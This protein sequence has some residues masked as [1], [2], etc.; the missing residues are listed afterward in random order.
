MQQRERQDIVRAR[1]L[2]AAVAGIAVLASAAGFAL[3]VMRHGL[4]S[5]VVL[6]VP[7]IFVGFPKPEQQNQGERGAER[8]LAVG[9]SNKA[10]RLSFAGGA[11]AAACWMAASLN[12]SS[13]ASQFFNELVK[14]SLVS[15]A[16]V[17]IF[18]STIFFI[19]G[20]AKLR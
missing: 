1:G 9:Y 2:Y 6:I 16:G 5:L 20:R 4:A 3:S 8:Q 7:L 12:F 10:L 17:L 15:A 11:S 14:D 19:V 13:D 18:V